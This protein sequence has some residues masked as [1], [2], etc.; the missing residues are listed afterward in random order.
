MKNQKKPTMLSMGGVLSPKSN[1]AV[2]TPSKISQ[3]LS[4]IKRTVS[5]KTPLPLKPANTPQPGKTPKKK[6]RL[7]L[8]KPFIAIK[9]NIFYIFTFVFI[10]GLYIFDI[11]R[12]P[13]VVSGPSNTYQMP[14]DIDS[15]AFL[16]VKVA[17][18]SLHKLHLGGQ[19]NARYISVAIMLLSLAFFYKFISNW[20]SRRMSVVAVLLFACSSWSLFQ[21]RQDTVTTMM[22]ALVPAILYAGGL[23]ISTNSRI[24]KILAGIILAQ[25]VFVPGAVW[26]FI[27]PAVLALI[28][29][30]ETFSFRSLYLPLAAFLA[31]IAGYVALI[32]HWS[33]DSYPQLLRLVGMEVGDLPALSTIRVN[34]T[35]LPSQL[36]LRGINDSS[37]WLKG[38]PIVDWVTI[39]FLLLGFIYSYKTKL[40]PIGKKVLWVFLILSLLLILVNGVTYV[41]V[42]LPLLYILIALGITHLTDQWM[43]IF[44]NN[45]LARSFGLVVVGLVIIVVCAFHVERYFIGWP[46]TDEYHQIYKN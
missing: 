23:A 3:N 4:D 33:L 5:E 22:L 36:F 32:I 41:S 18:I 35:D 31:M 34:A 9:R 45:P 19:L 25:F 8:K 20:L 29:Q 11:N 12:F 13:P 38:T 39:I 6:R 42:I 16:P 17:L 26:F 46:K 27:L 30:K 37:L 2:S 1:R 10:I 15:V 44:P 21:T 40:Y 28:Y 7:S 43:V 14:S 24:L